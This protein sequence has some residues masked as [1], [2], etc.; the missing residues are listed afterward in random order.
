MENSPK[1]PL[2]CKNAA[3]LRKLGGVE[4]SG[5]DKKPFRES[6]ADALVS[7]RRKKAAAEMN[8]RTGQY[9]M[10]KQCGDL[11]N[12]TRTFASGVFQTSSFVPAQ[13]ESTRKS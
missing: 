13:T 9:C 8:K 1:Y 4:G 7:S 5:G 11:K 10:G 12:T 3:Y 2:S 6:N